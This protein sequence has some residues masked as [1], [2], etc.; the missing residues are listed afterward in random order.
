M[1]TIFK[2]T[3]IAI[4]LFIFLDRILSFAFMH[5]IF[6]NTI[7]GESGGTINYVIKKDSHPDFL[8][9]GASRAK[10]EIDPS[11]L[12]SLG[13]NGYNLGINGNTVLTSS[14]ILDILLR[15]GVKPKTVLVQ[16]DLS[17]FTDDSR[18]KTLDQISRVYPYD[19]P[20]I[21]SYVQSIGAEEEV[22]YFF[23]LY[24]LNRKILDVGY[25][26]LKR[27]SIGAIDGF[28]GLPE[29]AVPP[30][31]SWAAA[32]YIYEGT[33]TTALALEH[34]QELCNE[35]SIDLIVVFPPFYNNVGYNKT[36]QEIMMNDLKKHGL[37]IMIDLSDIAKTP[38]LAGADNWRDALHMDTAGAEKFSIILNTAIEK[39][40]EGDRNGQ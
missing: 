20:L 15:N 33:S 4:I 3:A 7:S 13:A 11:V 40:P 36:Q 12:P 27:N 18:Q 28:V 14:L 10:H 17:D 24:R 6:D 9:L 19:T 30:D 35:N 2:K 37:K 1:L 8:I 26:F 38:G 31:G 23:G 25:N 22:K 16:T 34:M 29:I 5:I 32:N 21:R 39:L